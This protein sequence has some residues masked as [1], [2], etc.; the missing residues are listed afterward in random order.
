MVKMKDPKFFD[1]AFNKIIKYYIDLNKN[2]F[3]DIFFAKILEENG[4]NIF[5]TNSF[6]QEIQPILIGQMGVLYKLCPFKYSGMIND[7]FLNFI[8]INFKNNVVFLTTDDG[9][10]VYIMLMQTTSSERI[11]VNEYFAKNID[12]LNKYQYFSSEYDPFFEKYKLLTARTHTN[13]DTVK[14]IILTFS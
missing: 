12:E 8:S 11:M 9:F 10:L 3:K 13:D 4:D 5:I 2:V 7:D 14:D 1:E 6:N